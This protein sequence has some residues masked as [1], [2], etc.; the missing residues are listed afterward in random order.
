VPRVIRSAGGTRTYAAR[1]DIERGSV[2]FV[3]LRLADMFD[4][5]SGADPVHFYKRALSLRG[6]DRDPD[7]RSMGIME[8]ID[9]IDHLRTA[10][11]FQTRATLYLFIIVSFVFGYIVLA[12]GGTW[13]ALRRFQGLK[14]SWPAF[15]IVAAVAS[16]VSLAA[17]RINSGLGQKLDQ[18]TILDSTVDTYA[19]SGMCYFGLKT[20][21]MDQLDLWLPSGWEQ[22]EEPQYTSCFLRAMP[23]RTDTFGRGE[24]RFAD[25]QRYRSRSIRAALDDVP[26]RA[27]LKQFEGFWQGSL[28]GQMHADIRM[29]ANPPPRKS[30]IAPGSFLTN[31]LGHDLQRCF[32][33]ESSLDP[34]QYGSSR[35]K[36]I[37][38]HYIPRIANGE[39]L[40]LD[41]IL[42]AEELDADVRKGADTDEPNLQNLQHSCVK[43]LNSRLLGPGTVDFGGRKIALGSSPELAALLLSTYA[44]FTLQVDERNYGGA[45]PDLVRTHGQTL[46]RSRDIR[47]D[48]LLLVAFSDETGPAVLRARRG[49]GAYRPVAV[50]GSTIVHRFT[51]PVSRN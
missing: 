43:S 46:D 17:V 32:L 37:L 18:L 40:V 13:L 51:I 6:Q 14:Y 8:P 45:G 49:D 34:D 15:G 2:V 30:R 29:L 39:R 1:W 19:A 5:V 22:A 35:D 42:L 33:F 38:V 24:L 26:M 12:A 28:S 20:S 47:R 23:P 36:S 4:Q 48:Q 44:E 3:G 11:D 27:T 9:L 21:T 10:I 41:E 25:P 50:R 16:A 7:A 31:D